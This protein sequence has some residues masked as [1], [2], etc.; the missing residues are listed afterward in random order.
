MFEYM[1]LNQS[2]QK[3]WKNRDE[4]SNKG[5][6]W[7]RITHRLLIIPRKRGQSGWQKLM[8]NNIGMKLFKPKKK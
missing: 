5:R 8:Y 6:V 1:F 3:V 2:R 7:S 4:I